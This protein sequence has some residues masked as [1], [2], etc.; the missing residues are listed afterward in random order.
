MMYNRE[1]EVGNGGH[2]NQEYGYKDVL[3]KTNQENLQTEPFLSQHDS[4]GATRRRKPQVRGNG[5]VMFQN[6]KN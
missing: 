1:E 5:N 2:H 6:N 3:S 4:N